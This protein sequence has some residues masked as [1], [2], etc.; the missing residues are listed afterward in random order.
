MKTDR[1]FQSAVIS[2]VSLIHVGLIMLGW[3]A[4]K[5]PEPVT[6]DNLT[7][8]DLGTPEG[9][10][11]PK[12]E[13]APAPLPKAAEPPPPPKQETPK[14][15]PK[16]AEPPK[17][18]EP[19]VKT[20]V[21]DDVKPDVAAAKPLTPKPP[22]EPVKEVKPDPKPPAEPPKTA[23]ATPPANTAGG[24]PNAANRAE[25]APAGGGGGT[26]PDSKVPGNSGGGTKGADGK[27]AKG[28]G[29]GQKSGGP[30][31][32]SIVDGSYVNLPAPPY[33]PLALENGE[34]GTVRI[35]VIVEADGRISSAKIVK[36]SGS[37][38]LD[39]AALKAARGA[40]I[41]PKVING[42]PVRSRFITPFNFKVP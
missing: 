21:R 14:P 42:E 24:N 1:L 38:R 2:V 8:I 12:A 32:T 19:P 37:T 15:K 31:S 10:D 29:D 4:A 9:D 34:E 26:D 11:Q 6:V 13:G 35:E 30:G 3:Q 16:T 41:R 25:N 18:V 20:V 22:P 36:R 23:A 7:F 33:P 39:N 40:N 17:P 5:L 27:G 28:P